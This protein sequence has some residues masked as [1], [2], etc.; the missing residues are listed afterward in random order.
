MVIA[1]VLVGVLVTVLLVVTT[2]MAYIGRLGVRAA[3]ARRGSGAA[4]EVRDLIVG[5]LTGRQRA[6]LIAIVIDGASPAA[7]AMELQTTPGAI[8]KAPHDARR[9]L[10]AVLALT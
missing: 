9:K 8:Y 6:V 2:V 1:Q 7:R 3:G 5:R 4:W 10:T